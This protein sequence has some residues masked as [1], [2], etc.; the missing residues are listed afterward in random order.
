MAVAKIG[1]CFSIGCSVQKGKDRKV[2]GISQV[3]YPV[4]HK[5]CGSEAEQKQWKQ[6]KEWQAKEAN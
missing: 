1:R 5:T 2:R 4:L 6:D 3:A